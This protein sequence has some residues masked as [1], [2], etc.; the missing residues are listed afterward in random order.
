MTK[1]GLV[2]ELAR[3]RRATHALCWM[4]TSNCNS[5]KEPSAMMDFFDKN[6]RAKKL[7][8]MFDR[9][10]TERELDEAAERSKK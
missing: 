5:R 8:R 9:F 10:P 4:G 3:M 1:M 6:L 7:D 2:C